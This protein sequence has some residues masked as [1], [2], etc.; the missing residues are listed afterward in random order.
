MLP[1]GW[2]AQFKM[3]CL[4]KD[5]LFNLM[6]LQKT[7]MLFCPVFWLFKLLLVLSSDFCLSLQCLPSSCRWKA[8][9]WAS[10]AVHPQN[11]R[12]AFHE[13]RNSGVEDHVPALHLCHR[14]QQHPQG[15]HRHQRHGPAEVAK[16]LRSP[17][18]F[19]SVAW[20]RRKRDASPH[21][22]CCQD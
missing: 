3:L 13:P 22:S 16:G 1:V 8:E 20:G 21:S 12:A 11:V 2:L 6:P 15:F 19:Y 18:S 10:K 14:H 17:L 4:P 9:R 5:V 7:E